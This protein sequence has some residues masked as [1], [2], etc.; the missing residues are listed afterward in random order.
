MAAE[1]DDPAGP[2]PEDLP[3]PDEVK[4]LLKR[5]ERGDESALPMLRKLFDRRREH[6]RGFDIAEYAREAVIAPLAGKNLAVRELMARK[7]A[8][9]AAELAGPDPTPIERL[10]AERAAFCWHVV[11]HYE[12]ANAQAG[13]ITLKQA[14]YH[15]RRIDAAHRR[16]LTALRTL[17]AVR[18]LAVPALQVN[19]AR[20][21][22]NVAGQG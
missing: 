19:I 7:M 17:A 8:E 9:V 13:E 5:S 22:V 20:N 4:A 18:K 12:R 1:I 15:Q 6:F 3:S 21:Q 2:E 14:D 10:L 11:H 16:Y